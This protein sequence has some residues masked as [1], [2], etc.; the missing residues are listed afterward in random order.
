MVQRRGRDAVRRRHG[1]R[2]TGTNQQ[3]CDIAELRQRQRYRYR[4]PP[5]GIERILEQHEHDH[6]QFVRFE[7]VRIDER[8]DVHFRD[9]VE[10]DGGNVRH[11]VVQHIPA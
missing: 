7:L 3:Y 4:L 2:R 8:E 1:G 11:G 5:A 9:N 10:H 6:I